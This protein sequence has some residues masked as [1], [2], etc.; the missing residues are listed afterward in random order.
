[1]LDQPVL[2]D[3]QVNSLHALH[4]T[5]VVNLVLVIKNCTTKNQF[6][7]VRR[8]FTRGLLFNL[9]DKFLVAKLTPCLKP[10]KINVSKF[11]QNYSGEASE[12]PDHEN[13]ISFIMLL[14]KLD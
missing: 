11:N 2:E 6:T 8:A 7:G 1:M 10:K 12:P 13:I 14:L 4:Q 5:S 3:W 9:Y